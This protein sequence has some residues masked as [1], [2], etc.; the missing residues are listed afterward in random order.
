MI[1]KGLSLDQFND[2]MAKLKNSQVCHHGRYFKW[3]CLNREYK[4]AFVKT[5]R[6]NKCI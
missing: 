1:K 6:L 2:V 3:G 5:T 4:D